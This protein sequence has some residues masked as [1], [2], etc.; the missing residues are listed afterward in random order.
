MANDRWQKIEEIFEIAVE[1]PPGEREAYLQRTCGDDAELRREIEQLLSADEQAEEFIEEPL[2]GSHTLANFLDEKVGDIENSVPPHFLGRRVGA[3]RLIRELG[4]GGMGAVFLASR[5]DAEF[6]KSVA[7]KLIKRGM[8]TDFI[9][10]RFRNERQILATLDHPFIARLLDGGTTDDELPYFVMEYIEGTPIHQYCDENRLSIRERLQLFQKV[11]SAVDYAHRNLI[12]H[13]DLKP[14]NILVTRDV[15]P[16][17]LDFG[18]AKILNPEL[19]ADTLAPTLTGMRL[20]TPEYASPE[21]IRGE[22]LTP[23]SDIYSLGVLLYE[24]LTGKRPYRFSSRAPHEIARVVCEEKPEDPATALTDDAIPSVLKTE[25]KENPLEIL[26]RNRRTTPE[27]LLKELSGNLK[28]ILFKAMRKSPANRYASAEELS[29]DIQA[30]LDGLPVSAPEIEL[31]T[32]EPFDDS[33]PPGEAL[34]ILPFRMFRW[35]T[36]NGESDTGDFL[37]IGLADALISRL[38]GLKNISVRPTGSVVKFASETAD[39]ENAGR[40]LGVTHILDGRIQHIGNRVRVT[41]QLVHL[42]NN[43]TIWAGQF[44]EEMSDILALQDSISAQVADALIHQLTGE[45]R[46]RISKRGTENPKAYE[47]FLRGRFYWHS[48]EVENLAK[49]LVCFYEAIAHDPDFA[50]AYTGV[51]D[52]FNFLSVFGL[53]SPEESFPAA[54]EAAQKAIE[55]DDASA[56]AY[57]SL[58]VAILGYDWNFAESE[59]LLKKALELNPNYG[60]AHVWYGHL[61]GLQNKHEDALREMKRAERLNT[62]SASLLI[63]YAIRLRDARRFEEA[64]AK[65]REAQK[66]SPNYNISIQ[67]FSWVVDYLD[68][69]AEAEEACRVAYEKNENLSLPAYAYAYV[70][71]SNGKREEALRLAEK[72]EERKKQTYVPSSYLGLIYTALGEID[73]AYKW[74]D[75]AFAERD[76]W[77]IWLPVDPRYDALKTDP[78]FNLYAAKI[79]PADD[80]DIHLSHIPTR[81]FQPADLERP[82]AAAEKKE[83]EKMP[84]EAAERTPEKIPEKVPA[85]APVSK[86]GFPRRYAF[87][88]IAAAVFI[89]LIF[90]AFRYGLISVEIK[91]HPPAP[92]AETALNGELEKTLVILPF[93]TD[94][95]AENEESFGDGLADSIYKQLGQVKQISVRTAKDPVDETRSAREIGADFGANYVLRG[96]LHKT[97]DRIQVTA[98][99]FNA[100]ENKAVWLETFDQS[101]M[102]FPNLQTEIAEKV[103]KVLTVE[104]TIAERQRISRAY[105]ENSEAYQLYLVGRYQMRSRR[106]ENLRAAIETFERAKEKDPKFV[107]AYVG[108]ADAYALLNLYAIPPP[109][110]AYAEAKKNALRALELDDSVAEA[111]ASLAYILFYGDWNRTEAEKHFRRAIELNPS[112]STAHH[113][114]ALALA[115]M[116]KHEESIEQIDRA[117]LLEPRSAVIYSAAGLVYYFAHRYDDALKMC[118]K[119]LEIDPRF[120]PAYK[121]IRVIHEA[122][123]NY[124]EAAEAYEKERNFSG[125]ADEDTPGWEMI[126]AQVRS[127]GGLRAEAAESVKKAVSSTVVRENPRG[128]SNEIAIAYALLGDK[129]N[130]LEWI[131]KAKDYKDHGFNFINVDPRFDRLRSEPDFQ[132]IVKDVFR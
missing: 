88:S 78:R 73:Q 39:R 129:K 60:E 122:A 23:A 37:S 123:G 127:V 132:A 6:K 113:W 5:D 21:Q 20:M 9:L 89:G 110:G 121:T 82:K 30:Y 10:K 94:A 57:T 7:I 115:A 29:N 56:E 15:T 112:Y 65:I 8:D 97:I 104:L 24:L 53:M 64:L 27:T 44:D 59:R 22:K 120:V 75:R 101:I 131:A 80:E 90:L 114:F 74:L 50:L 18:I 108:L 17:L 117:V 48:Y 51:A 99:L 76:F 43:E 111:Q 45:E 102:D 32:G 40:E 14:G 26:S 118:R 28:N 95:D 109:D 38:S 49:S 36:S 93:T 125:N 46:A 16:K 4:R 66:M 124:A 67:A 12:I 130:A 55:L 77:A 87:A 58:A 98:E 2:L 100:S 81:I 70:L 35:R 1:L 91:K 33:L 79:R 72:L 83:P 128:Y 126:T 13:R 41:A 68:I 47:A 11:C 71:A 62:V 105:T 34:A 116:G 84:E 42:R 3:Y 85:P 107:L 63:N 31:S 92:T 119:S 86:E 61:L 25:N 103:L 52:Y 54:R 106:A 19:A 69:G 96:R